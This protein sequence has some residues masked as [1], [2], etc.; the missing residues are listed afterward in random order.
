MAEALGAALDV[1]KGEGEGVALG[2]GVV[3][4]LPLGDAGGVGGAECV[5][6]P[7]PVWLPVGNA[8]RVPKT[9]ALVAARGV[10]DVEAKEWARARGGGAGQGC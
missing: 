3:V 7:L 1:G 8:E 2:E 4:A 6:E 10:G 9:E 5:V